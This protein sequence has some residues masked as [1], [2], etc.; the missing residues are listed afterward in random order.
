M[1]S[2]E[3]SKDYVH[4]VESYLKTN[5]KDV[6]MNAVNLASWETNGND[7][8]EF[9][10]LADPYLYEG[11]DLITIQ[12]GEN[13]SN[14][15]TWESDFEQLISYI[16]KKCPKAQ[17]IVVGDFWSNGNRDRD[18]EAAANAK[19]VT[20]VSLDGIKDNKDY[21]AGLGTTV[22]GKKGDMHTIEHD[23]VANHPGDKGMAA[24]AERITTK[25]DLSK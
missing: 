7:R 4:L 15:D 3:D 6:T 10:Q 21:Y 22:E 25:I 24:I 14:L 12:L 13:A 11:L 1:A 8:A 17:I 20:Y 19:G 9:L 5:S 23:G 18:K 2:S 16:K